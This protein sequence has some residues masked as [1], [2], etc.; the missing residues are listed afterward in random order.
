VIH[1]VEGIRLETFLILKVEK[2]LI[3]LMGTW[4][5]TVSIREKQSIFFWQMLIRNKALR[6]CRLEERVL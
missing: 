3:Y 4:R 2:S 1:P 6:F 5:T